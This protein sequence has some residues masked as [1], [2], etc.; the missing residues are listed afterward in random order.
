MRTL[1]LLVGETNPTEASNLKL[2]AAAVMAPIVMA[3]AAIRLAFDLLADRYQRW[4]I[5]RA[6]GH[7]LVCGCGD[8]ARA[9]ARNEAAH[10]RE[11]I[12]VAPA[13]TQ[14]DR[15][16]CEGHGIRLLRGDP[17][18][19]ETLQAAAVGRA[20]R[21]VAIT[22]DDADNLQIAMTA[23]ELLAAAP[24]RKRELRAFAALDDRNLWHELARSDSIKR[25]SRNFDFGLFNLSDIVARRFFW[26]VPLYQ[27]ADLRDQ[28]RI[29]AVFLGFGHY[30]EALLLQMLR[31]CAYRDLGDPVVTVLCRDA[32][33]AEDRLH[34]HSPEAD[35]I[36][37]IEFVG[38]D[39]AARPLDESVMTAV[40][41]RGAVTAV[42]VCLDSDEAA[43]QAA[44]YVRDVMHRSS[45]WSAPV[46]AQICGDTGL[47]DLLADNNAARR[48]DDV[49]EVFGSDA[50]NCD[51]RI[52]DGGLEITAR[53][54]HEAYCATR[55]ENMDDDAEAVRQESLADWEELRETYRASNRRAA[56]HV[57]AKLESAGCYVTDGLELV[58]PT[59]FCLSQNREE[60]EALATLEHHSW[61]IGMR[62]DGWRPAPRRNNRRREHDNLVAYE[63]LTEDLKD[64]DRDQ[65]DL[66]DTRLI[67][68]T[69]LSPGT[70]ALRHDHW[71]GLI[72]RTQVD[73]DAARW[74][75]DAL[76]SQVLTG[77]TDR[78]K[79][80]HFTLVTPF[81][82]GLDLVLTR[83][84][85]SWFSEHRIP[86]R[87][88]IVS[89]VPD[90]LML[91]DYR[92][93]FEAGSA[94]NGEP[95][96]AG[97][98]WKDTAAPGSGG[99]AAIEAARDAT[100][101]D[102]A[103]TWIIDLSR[104]DVDYTNTTERP[105][106]INGQATTSPG[107]AIR[108]LRPPRTT[109][110]RKREAR[111]RL[112]SVAPRHSRHA[113]RP[114]RRRCTARLSCS[115]WTGARYE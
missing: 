30:G 46:Y 27:Y 17:R 60:R 90:E 35:K 99:R 15:S 86:H 12:I 38:A 25:R 20:D 2:D 73:V 8:R 56:D 10:E 67:T 21:L 81:A 85:L 47:G 58:A 100:T 28:P 115:S 89:G 34:L 101:Q 88:L 65:I 24:A 36:A 18:E 6:A 79:D 94:W 39:V 102:D 44:M 19:P 1:Q 77:L 57:R 5:S 42:I 107:A 55:R 103:C 78:N 40:E 16:F 111:W 110:R 114:G 75:A 96:T 93:A 14:S 23:R 3:A 109:R 95:R 53:R 98:P 97:E 112:S 92:D 105:W 91:D 33:A 61:C 66:I 45:R 82:P 72:G 7:T 76:A 104:A 80:A 62:L 71:I 32:A 54:I 113:T 51:F 48:F 74:A 63:A 22:G 84:A 106:A 26:D 64:F 108:S 29:H 83:A 11:A 9:F 31:A 70:A 59:G 50:D 37:N 43:L 52:I 13:P 69:D 87:L 68:R 41:F 4:R 49:I